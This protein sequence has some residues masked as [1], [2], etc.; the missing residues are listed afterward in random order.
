MT[1]Y[2]LIQALEKRDPN[3]E[4]VLVN[5]SDQQYADV[6]RV[7]MLPDGSVGVVG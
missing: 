5:E 7:E 2:E 1:V 4:V 6:A 3:A